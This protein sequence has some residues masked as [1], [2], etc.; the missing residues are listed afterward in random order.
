MFGRLGQ[1]DLQLARQV[2]LTGAIT[3]ELAA[4]GLGQRIASDQHHG[5]A[6]ELVLGGH[7]HGDGRGGCGGIVQCRGLDLGDHDQAFLLA[8]FH[9]EGGHTAL[10]DGWVRRHH[11]GLDVHR[12][13]VAALED[14]HLFVATADVQHAPVHEAQ[15]ACSQVSAQWGAVTFNARPE[16]AVVVLGRA[17]P[18]ALRH[19]WRRQPDLT[20]F[21]VGQEAGGVGVDDAHVASLGGDQAANQRGGG[22]RIG[23]LRH[24]TAGRLQSLGVHRQ[25]RCTPI[26]APGQEQGGLGRTKDVGHGLWL[27]ARALQP[28]GHALKGAMAHGLAAKQGVRQAGQVDV[29]ERIALQPAQQEFVAEVGALGVRCAVLAHGF[30]PQAWVLQ[31][32]HGREEHHARPGVDRIERPT[33][34]AHVVEQGHPADQYGLRCDVGLA[35]DCLHVV[36]D[37]AVVDHHAL[38]VGGRARGVLQVGQGASAGRGNGHARIR[39]QGRQAIGADPG[40]LG[41]LRLLR[42]AFGDAMPGSADQGCGVVQA[43]GQGYLAATVA[44]QVRKAWD[45]DFQLARIRAGNRDGHGLGKQAAQEADQ[46]LV[47]VGRVGQGHAVAGLHLGI[48]QADGA[49]HGALDHGLVGERP[50]LFAFDIQEGGHQGI[51]RLFIALAHDLQNRLGTGFRQACCWIDRGRG[52]TR[53]ACGGIAIGLTR[54]ASRHQVFGKQHVVVRQLKGQQAARVIRA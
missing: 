35:T 15:V 33:H 40:E 53:V 43:R 32:A 8:V 9:R 50:H 28:L 4:A 2:G 51:G 31:E 17:P 39:C 3:L 27:K 30:N 38:R 11:R 29:F 18:I 20:H 23:A 1:D 36:Q 41:P 6:S 22:D 14:H 54:E 44:H 10:A 47:G 46:K 24:G 7:V 13:D 48:F 19:R 5:L 42:A 52:D 21:A 16:G 12:V 34:Q 37:V 49:G 45:V 26:V 25:Q